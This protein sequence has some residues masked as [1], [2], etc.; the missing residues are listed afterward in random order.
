MRSP[1]KKAIVYPLQLHLPLFMN[2]HVFVN[3]SPRGMRVLSGTVTS[4]SSTA[5]SLHAPVMLPVLADSV[6]S[7]VPGVIVVDGSGVV[8][9]GVAV[10]RDK[11]GRVGGRVEVTKRGGVSVK[12][13]GASLMQDVRTKM[14]SRMDILIFF[15]G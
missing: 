2:R 4:S 3:F 14:A 8:V 10:G 5:L 1:A 12:G 6:A 11:P 15:M 9:A 13:P 7:E